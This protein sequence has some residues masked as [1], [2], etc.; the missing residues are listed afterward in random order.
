MFALFNIFLS[1]ALR[2][3]LEEY[4]YNLTCRFVLCSK[5][6]KL[7]CILPNGTRLLAIDSYKWLYS[8]LESH[9]SIEQDKKQKENI[10]KNEKSCLMRGRNWTLDTVEWKLHSKESIP[11]PYCTVL[12]AH[13]KAMTWWSKW[14]HHILWMM[15]QTCLGIIFFCQ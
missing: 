9:S 15:C 1:L 12:F 2:V 6:E 10:K 5:V 7:V 11:I 13:V 3:R 8:A 4:D 14:C